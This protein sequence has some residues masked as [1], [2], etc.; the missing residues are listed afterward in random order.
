MIRKFL[1]RVFK[2][3]HAAPK[4]ATHQ[5]F[6]L[7]EHGIRREHIASSARRTCEGLQHAGYKA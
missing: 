3:G 6:S 1:G 2:R 7:D 4:A 5:T